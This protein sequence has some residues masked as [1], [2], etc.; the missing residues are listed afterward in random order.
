MTV[1]TWT[2]QQIP[3]KD[4]GLL[5][6]RPIRRGEHIMARTPAVMID[7]AAVD[8]LPIAAFSSLLHDA[9]TSLPE[10][11]CA[12]FFNLSARYG[13][14]GN[15]QGANVAYHIFATNAFRTGLADNEPDLH[16]VFRDGKQYLPVFLPLISLALAM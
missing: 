1:P 2:E 7:G 5:A 8:T 6:A 3:G 11:H 10:P 14:E 15:S 13:S 4:L 16:S 12:E 9:A